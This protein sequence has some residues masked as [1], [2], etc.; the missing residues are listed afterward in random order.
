MTDADNPTPELELAQQ[1]ALKYGKDL[2]QIYLAEKGKRE[3]LHVAYQA[4]DAIFA[5]IP[6]GLAVLDDALSIQQANA[7]FS[8]LVEMNLDSILGQRIDKVLLS[9]QIEPAMQRL[10]QGET[11]PS[12]LE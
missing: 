11:A 2:A 8:R 9:D 4:L 10:P 3:K 12:E 5:S 1:Q 6:D 7:A